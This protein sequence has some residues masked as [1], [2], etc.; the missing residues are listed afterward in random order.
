MG[1]EC[2][3]TVGAPSLEELSN[4][5]AFPKREDFIKGPIAVI[6]CIEE[7]PCNPCETSCRKGAI[8][9]GSPITNLPRIDF[10]KC[11]GCGICVAACP[12]LAIYIKEYNY[13]DQ[14]ARISFP[15]EYFPFPKEGEVVKLVGRKG[16]NVCLGTVVGIQRSKQNDG[17]AVV[18]VVYPKTFFDKVI[19]MERKK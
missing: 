6:E 12:G 7:I 3:K 16:E 10:E 13:S 9:V 1:K 2:L 19:S 15:Y 18:S 14:E 8:I 4:S 5:P 17:T 11:I